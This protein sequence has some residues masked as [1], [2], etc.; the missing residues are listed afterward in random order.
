MLSRPDFMAKQML[1][2]ESDNSKKLRLKNSNLILTDE[3]NKI[4]LQHPCS[5]IFMVFILGEFSIT[6]VLIKN[7]KK[8]AVPIVFLNYNLKPYFSILPDNKGNF[9]LRKK[10]YA[11]NNDLEI[12]KHVIGNKVKNQISLMNSLR[13]KTVKEKD[14]ISK[15]KGLFKQIIHAQNSQELLGIEG[16][17][18]KLFFETY[19]KNLNFNGRKPRCKDDIFNL[20]LDIGYYYLFNF[21]EAN[22]ELYG[23]DT[24][25]GFY[26]KLFFQRKSLVC[27]LVEP[28]RCIIDR[29]I[30]K[31]FN[32]KQINK[33]DFYF[34]NGQF[35]VKRNFNKKY[36]QLF[37]KEILQQKEKIFL[38]TQAYY[39]SFIKGKGID[40][41]PV[42]NIEGET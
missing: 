24:Y 16:T 28:F 1:F 34:K 36:S 15:M 32:L 39:R 18:S 21:I 22:L 3:N 26:H 41:F 29:R 25:C 31:S 6:S 30:R 13:Y 5:K 11:N 8:Y 23:F 10:Q 17:A 7:A 19:F 40:N 37:L 35:Y 42:F 9:L 27:D 2:I 4:V 14:N 20:L 38:Y 12:A 33:D